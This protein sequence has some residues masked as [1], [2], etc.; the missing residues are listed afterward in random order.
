[1]NV[2]VSRVYT[3]VDKT[4]LGHQHGIEGRL[5]SGQ[6]RL[7]AAQE[8]GTLRFDM[9][10]FQADGEAARR[11]VGLTGLTDEATRTKVTANM[12]GSDVLDV[13]RYPTATLTVDSAVATGGTTSTGKP[14]YELRG[15]F[16]LHGQTQNVRIP[17]EVER[18]RGW[19]HVQGRFSIRQSAYGIEPYSTAFGAVG[20][21]DALVIHGDLWIAPS[22]HV[23]LET[24]PERK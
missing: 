24:I 5:E 14:Q 9:R 11:Y 3:F 8:A 20:V 23:A 18:A 7:G 16:E 6:L 10:S 15:R 2:E 4:G 21:A 1:V 19:L 17:V 12:L 13:E 22:E